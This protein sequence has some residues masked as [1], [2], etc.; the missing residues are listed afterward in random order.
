MKPQQLKRFAK[1]HADENL[2]LKKENMKLQREIVRMNIRHEYS[3]ICLEQMQAFIQMN[4]CVLMQT[5]KSYK[6]LME[7]QYNTTKAFR[8]YMKC[9]DYV[10]PELCDEEEHYECT[11]TADVEVYEDV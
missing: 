8:Y 4:V 5:E 3:K 7:L 1:I 9:R 10:P 2:K 11:S 6:S